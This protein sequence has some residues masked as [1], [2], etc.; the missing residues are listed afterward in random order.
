MH[1]ESLSEK[2]KVAACILLPVS[3]VDGT[4]YHLHKLARKEQ[5]TK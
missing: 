4:I 5:T 3:Q 1:E 2:N